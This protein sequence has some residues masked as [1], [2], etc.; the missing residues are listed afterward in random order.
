MTKKTNFKGGLEALGE[1]LPTRKLRLLMDDDE[2]DK[3]NL[4]LS[5]LEGQKLIML[6]MHYELEFGNYRGIALALA[7]E[8]EPG[9][10]EAKPKNRPTKWNEAVLGFLYVAVERARISVGRKVNS[11]EIYS[12]VANQEPWNQFLE[13]V[14]SIGVS[15]D[16]AEAI[17]RAYFKAKKQKQ[18]KKMWSYYRQS[19]AKGTVKK[20]DDFASLYVKNVRKE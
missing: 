17:R 5:E 2:V 12:A 6:L 8:H 14:D 15:S 13:T 16:P 4:E 19:K 18:G 3:A 1:A 9:F 11:K 10:N 7:R 20:F